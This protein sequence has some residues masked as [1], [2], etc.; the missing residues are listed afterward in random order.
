MAL[1]AQ[2][3]SVP[4]IDNA[5]AITADSSLTQPTITNIANVFTAGLSGS[6]IDTI[7]MSAVGTTVAGQLRL[8]VRKGFAGKTISSITSS[9]TTATVTT[10][11]THG[12][13]TG[14]L[15]TIQNCDPFE[16]NVKDASITVLTATTFTYTIT[17]VANASANVIGYYT[18][19]HL[20]TVAKY[21]L[22]REI[23]FTAV[24]PSAT[25][26]AYNNQL[27]SSLNP[28]MLPLLLPAGYAL[29][30]TVSTTQSSAGI[31]VIANG[32]DF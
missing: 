27:S 18:A 4:K 26:A 24:T 23:T 29:C 10:S 11:S 6:R 15:V 19:C 30:A 14:D 13:I 21:S 3:A 9:T 32:G 25:V 31:N 22:L 20:G 8:F 2:Y 16:F 28:E 7:L 17:T 12:L 1:T 5:V